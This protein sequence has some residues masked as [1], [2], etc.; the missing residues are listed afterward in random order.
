MFIPGFV[1]ARC[2]N[3]PQRFERELLNILLYRTATPQQPLRATLRPGLTNATVLA[4]LTSV[5]SARKDTT[6]SDVLL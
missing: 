4:L 1:Q 6:I 2:E 5:P 3:R